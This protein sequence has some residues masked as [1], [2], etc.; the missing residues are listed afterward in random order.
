M[1]D[2][3][4]MCVGH[5]CFD[6]TFAVPHHPGPDEKGVAD[7]LVSSGGGPAANAAVTVARL[8]LRA[9]FAGY[10]GKDPWGERYLQE[11]FDEGVDT[12]F[13]VRGSGPTPLSAILAKPDGKRTVINYHA[14]TDYLPAGR[15]G[16]S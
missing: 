14:E 11:L 3:D 15:P 13:V 4:V 10:L 6:L 1:P 5:A 12:A 2:I 8:G 7:A 16:V 9:A